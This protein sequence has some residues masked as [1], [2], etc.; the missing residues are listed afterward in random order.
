MKGFI[1]YDRHIIKGRKRNVYKKNINAK[2]LYIKKNNQ[3]IPY[4]I[5]QKKIYKGGHN[6]DLK[7]ID[8]KQIVLY[9][10]DDKG[11]KEFLVSKYPKATKIINYN[12][13]KN[14]ILLTYQNS[15]DKSCI[16][17]VVKNGNKGFSLMSLSEYEYNNQN[18]TAYF[19]Y[20]DVQPPQPILWNKNQNATD[21]EIVLFD[22][23][24][25]LLTNFETNITYKGYP[26]MFQFYDNNLGLTIPSLF[27]TNID[28]RHP[29]V[30][31]L[32]NTEKYLNL[33]ITSSEGILGVYKDSFETSF[34]SKSTKNKYIKWYVF[35]NKNKKVFI[36][37]LT[38]R[39]YLTTSG[40]IITHYRLYYQLTKNNNHFQDKAKRDVDLI[41]YNVFFD[42]NEN[43]TILF[44][45]NEYVIKQFDK[46][47]HKYKKP[48][49]D[50]IFKS[51][52]LIPIILYDD[53]DL[54]YSNIYKYDIESTPCFNKGYQ[55][56]FYEILAEKQNYLQYVFVMQ[57]LSVNNVNIYI[58]K[59]NIKYQIGYDKNLE[60]L[61][62]INYNDENILKTFNINGENIKLD[63]INL[64]H[65]IKNETEIN[66]HKGY[67]GSYPAVYLEVKYKDIS[68]EFNFVDNKSNIIEP[69]S[70]HNLAGKEII[71]YYI[72]N[73]NGKSRKHFLISHSAEKELS[74]FIRREIIPNVQAKLLSISEEENN[75]DN[76]KWIVVQNEDKTFSLRTLNKYN[77][78]FNTNNEDQKKYG[79]FN[80]YHD[81]KAQPTLWNYTDHYRNKIYLTN[82]FHIGR[83]NGS[84][85]EYNNNIIFYEF[86]T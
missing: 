78:K 8:Q 48:L 67:E 60:K 28:L 80:Y 84:Y 42:I 81:T 18:Y 82:T 51:N 75:K 16:W 19:N 55:N 40:N 53:K 26:I 49:L 76:Y 25:F 73:E 66:S 36:R 24:Y 15:K 13:N 37:D 11:K 3:M 50:S 5:Y 44:D 2:T 21:F 27:N 43:N 9:F 45:N 30:L 7:D 56:M 4:K 64:Q 29:I 12:K 86:A 61:V 52:N 32:K 57:K 85:I 34:I 63:N 47:L 62:V 70:L 69:P 71:L 38:N 6:P 46:S 72:T 17:K 79:Y 39:Y 20:Y 65:K 77:N 74:S 58:I 1:L 59:N 54:L 83:Q 10:F 14:P 22:D 68:E 41:N 35:I 23:N 33:I 31:N